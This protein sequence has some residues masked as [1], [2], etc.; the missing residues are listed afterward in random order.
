VSLFTAASSFYTRPNQV[1]WEYLEPDRKVFVIRRTCT[2]LLPGA[3]RARRFRSEFIGKRPVPLHRLGQ[4]ID[5]LGKYYEFQPRCGERHQG[6]PSA[7]LQP[8]K[9]RLREHV[10]EMKI[11]S[12]LHLPAAQ[13]QYIESDGELD[14]SASTTSA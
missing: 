3:K 14:P 4:S 9:K 2:S 8:R 1:R 5:D 11:W 12:R 6:H 13:L 10:A 7:L